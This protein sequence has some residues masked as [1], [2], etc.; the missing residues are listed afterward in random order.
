MVETL[1]EVNYYGLSST[2]V[3][4]KMFNHIYAK[5]PLVIRGASYAITASIILIS[6]W[7][8][9][10]NNEKTKPWKPNPNGK[11]FVSAFIENANNPQADSYILIGQ[12]QPLT[13]E[14]RWAGYG[15]ETQKRYQPLVDDPKIIGNFITPGPWGYSL[16]PISSATI[17]IISN[18]G[19]KFDFEHVDLGLYKNGELKNQIQHFER[20]ELMIEMDTLLATSSYSVPEQPSV[21]HS[22]TVTVDVYLDTFTN[23]D[24]DWY[25]ENY[26]P[27][28]GENVVPTHLEATWD[29]DAVMGFFQINN[30]YDYRNS[31]F[32]SNESFAFYEKGPFFR[33]GVWA[34]KSSPDFLPEHNRHVPVIWKYNEA[35]LRRDIDF[36]HLRVSY[37]DTLGMLQ[38]GFV[39][40][41][42][43]AMYNESTPYWQLMIEESE[44]SLIERDYAYWKSI[45]N[46]EAFQIENGTITDT[47]DA[48]GAFNIF[49][50]YYG[51][52]HLVPN[53][54]GFD[55]D[56][57]PYWTTYTPI[58]EDF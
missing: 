30:L 14:E 6:I 2:L 44:R 47:V 16:K 58:P 46:I 26:D 49:G 41:F 23:E 25:G 10:D 4:V 32:E 21:M 3:Y 18:T 33:F 34:I 8:C 55:P 24:G 52:Y 27:S 7:A 37:F 20:L 40:G 22:D 53:R 28:A 50:S 42:Y 29:K 17:S 5:A 9:E 15:K 45:S 38:G 36:T 56:T 11:L 54:I 43:Q 1:R 13:E 48:Y 39:D 35:M 57:I 19:E 31:F 12:L 51:T